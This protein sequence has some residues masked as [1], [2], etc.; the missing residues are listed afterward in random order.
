M[1]QKLNVGLTA[2]A[3]WGSLAADYPNYKQYN[4]QGA[5][6]QYADLIAYIDSVDFQRPVTP[7]FPLALPDLKVSFD[8]QTFD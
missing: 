2:Y 8:P 1:P 5:V 7:R 4:E 3:D 6:T